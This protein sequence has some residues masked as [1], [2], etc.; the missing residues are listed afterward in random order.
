[1]CIKT[2]TYD[3]TDMPMATVDHL[4]QAVFTGIF[5]ISHP[6]S[7]QNKLVLISFFPLTHTHTI[8]SY[9]SAANVKVI[10]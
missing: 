7:F 2:F 9:L 5:H 1:M 10:N 4:M 3:I 8:T 6:P